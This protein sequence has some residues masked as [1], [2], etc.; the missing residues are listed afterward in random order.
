MTSYQIIGILGLLLGVAACFM[1]F[2]EHFKPL[3]KRNLTRYGL[4]FF[5]AAIMMGASLFMIVSTL[6][7]LG[8]PGLNVLE[9][10]G[11][12]GLLTT[13][14]FPLILTFLLIAF[15]G[16]ANKEEEMKRATGMGSDRMPITHLLIWGIRIYVAILFIFSGFVKA[17]D[18]IGFSY[19]LEEYFQVFANYMPALEGFW[20]FWEGLALPLAWFISV[21]EIALAVAILVGWRMRITALLTL[22]MMI[23]FTILTAFSA[24]TGEVTDCGCFGDALKLE[25]WESFTKDL[26]YMVM[27]VPVYLL[28]KEIKPF[29]NNKI[30]TALTVAAFILSGVYAWYCHE[31]LPQ[32]DYRAYK[33]GTDLKICTTQEDENGEI[34][35]KDWY[36]NYYFD[37]RAAEQA[38]QDTNFVKPPE[39][40]PLQGKVL[41]VFMAKIEK[42]DEEAVKGSIE[43]ASQIQPAGVQVVGMS[44]AYRSLLEEKDDQF[45]FNYP[46]S[47]WDAKMLK[48]VVRSN[49]GYVLMQDGVILGKWHHNNAP[50]KAEIEALL[51]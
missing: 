33:V 23:F 39:V 51:K 11:G 28:R 29:P 49:P 13:M 21:F 14:L 2:R 31:N 22:L 26:I 18:Y 40:D 16:R 37:F 5:G 34:K 20:G 42:A 9:E 6:A 27:L 4:F 45:K 10:D 44:S 32:V 38:E 17:N 50:D 47:L 43:L 15:M 35:C 19:K 8:M 1:M 46:I 3:N 12:K 41:A 25:P 36:Q 7:E 24:I 30:A 48:T